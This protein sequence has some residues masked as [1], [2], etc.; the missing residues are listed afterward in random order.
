[1]IVSQLRSCASVTFSIKFKYSNA[2]LLVFLARQ[3]VAFDH[4]TLNFCSTR[5]INLCNHQWRGML[6]PSFP[7]PG[8]SSLSM[9]RLS[10]SAWWSA[11]WGTSASQPT[12]T[13]R[14]WYSYPDGT[15][16]RGRIIVFAQK[17]KK[18][19][20]KKHI[21]F[22]SNFSVENNLLNNIILT[23]IALV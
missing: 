19:S 14:C 23:N 16:S 3:E 20:W 8:T 13:V 5:I 7:S 1:M 4:E 2:P 15:T 18:K 9:T 22:S 11:C 12:R 10:T 17:K 6:P 21:F